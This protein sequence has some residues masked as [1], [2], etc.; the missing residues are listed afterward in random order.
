MNLNPSQ[1]QAVERWGQDVCVVAGPGSGKTRTLVERYWW[2]LECAEAP[3]PQNILAVT[4]TEKAA[5]EMKGRL[6]QTFRERA[7]L[8]GVRARVERREIERA[9]VSTLHGYCLRL[10]KENALL[11][12]VDPEFRILDESSALVFTYEAAEESLERLL[13]ESPEQFRALAEAAATTDLAACLAELYPALRV[14]GATMGELKDRLG[15]GAHDVRLRE[16]RKALEAIPE[17]ARTAWGWKPSQVEQF[18]C[19]LTWKTQVLELLNHPRSSTLAGLEE[20]P[21][22]HLGKMKKDNVQATAREIKKKVWPQARPALVSL[23]FKEERVILCRALELLDETYGARKRQLGALDFDDLEEQAI[24]LLENHADLRD[25]VRNGFQH[26]LMDEL[27]DTNPLQWKLMGLL[28][29]PGRFYGVGDVN[30]SIYGFRHAEPELFQ[31]YRGE[32]ERAGHAID[33]LRENY[34]SRREILAAVECIMEGAAGIEP[35]E[36]A[37][38]G[39]FIEADG[40]FVEVLACVVEEDSEASGGREEAHRIEAAWIAHRIREWV[41]WLQIT[42]G[43]SKPPRSRLLRYGDIAVLLRTTTLL[44]PLTNALE[45]AH[46]PYLLSKSAGFFEEREVRD[47]L[48]WLKIVAHP[49]DDIS[50]ATVLRSPLVGISDDTLL[51]LRVL[52]DFKG[53]LYSA[54]ARVD[55]SQCREWNL[56]DVDRLLEFRR[57]LARS[58][59]QADYVSPERL[60]VSEIDD[61]GYEVALSATGRQNVRRFLTRLRDLHLDSPESLADLVRRLESLREVAKEREAS[62]D[63]SANAVQ[64]LTMHGAKGLEFPVVFCAQLGRGTRPDS[65]VFTYSPDAGLGGRWRPPGS[66]QEFKDSGYLAYRQRSMQREEQEAN[67]LLYVAMTRARERLVLSFAVGKKNQDW[68][69]MIGKGLDLDWSNIDAAPA[70]RQPPGREFEV[71]VLCTA[72]MPEPLAEPPETAPAPAETVLPAR[73][74]TIARHDSFVP[75][76]HVA[77][78]EQCPRK[79][80]LARY[81]GWPER[82]TW[83]PL[84]AEEESGVLR[85]IDASDFGRQVHDLLAGISVPD[86]VP[87]AHSLAERFHKSDLGR[88]ATRAVQAHREF[89]F[90][91]ALE[92][93]IVGGQI[94]LWFEDERG[95]VIVDYKTDDVSAGEVE[96]RAASY[97]TQLQL[98][99]IGLERFTG[100][101]PSEAWLYFL[102]PSVAIPVPLAPLWLET[103]RHAVRSLRE[104][105]DSQQ[106]P[107][108]ED[109]H[110]W[111]CPYHRQACPAG[112]QVRDAEP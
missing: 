57:R 79:Y 100:R 95:I 14:A 29:S 24:H 35:G 20:D 46:I 30:Q 105:Q 37:A 78:F 5:N 108:H 21:P 112:R 71:R 73:P 70:I 87:D 27:Q 64:V 13:A 55:S 63:D 90:Q 110:C 6:V 60:L 68:L 65:P 28:R 99:A 58:R 42:D 81:L 25:Q 17:R 104:A 83:R 72:R 107:L 80:Y 51:R 9:P 4:F 32:V 33:K 41:G 82:E 40:P 45:Q 96:T 47:L 31:G 103:A 92:E 94:D 16:L 109:R 34:R 36:L 10:L 75:V 91:F 56:R 62:P 84:G 67:R 93:M 77:Q 53:S 12:G 50:L 101:L 85:D 89:D 54:L 18:E 102:R 7:A 52:S 49:L 11:A 39:D 48:H 23:C 3:R 88:R 66:N 111:T 69:N 44:D 19:L 76:T 74:A 2:L 98:Y 97:A 61:T 26:I 22:F 1:Q 38:E 59:E 8:D 43:D 106:F 86:A 15:E